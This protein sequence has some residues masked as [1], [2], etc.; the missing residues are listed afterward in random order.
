[1]LPMLLLSRPDNEQEGYRY[2][3]TYDI[4]MSFRKP[5]LFAG[6]AFFMSH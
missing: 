6:G 1:M 4:Q 5:L 2:E 3:L